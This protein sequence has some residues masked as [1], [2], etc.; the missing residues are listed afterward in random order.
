MGVGV[1][2]LFSTRW[3]YLAY[4]GGSV[5]RSC[6]GEVERASP[7]SL[8]FGTGFLCSHQTGTKDRSFD[9]GLIHHPTSTL[10]VFKLSLQS[11]ISDGVV[12]QNLTLQSTLWLGPLP[13]LCGKVSLSNGWVLACPRKHS[14][15]HAVP[16]VQRLWRST[17]YSWRQI[18]LCSG[19]FVPKPANVAAL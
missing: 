12:F 19:V 10:S 13:T 5:W 2:A 18:S 16:E 4:W 17:T 9:S 7:Y 1:T 15:D 14:C 8:V 3:H 6:A 11:F